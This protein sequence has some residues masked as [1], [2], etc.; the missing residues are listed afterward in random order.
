[1]YTLG[2]VQHKLQHNLRRTTKKTICQTALFRIEFCSGDLTF[3][4]S[5]EVKLNDI[6]LIIMYK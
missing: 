4:E 6:N 3:L 1:M 5:K 2:V